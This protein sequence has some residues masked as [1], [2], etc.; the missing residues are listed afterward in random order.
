MNA[1]ARRFLWFGA[2]A[3]GTCWVVSLAG[4]TQRGPDT[5]QHDV[6][7]A[8]R[9]MEQNPSATPFRERAP[10][11]LAIT[12]ST[13]GSERAPAHAAL[14][15]RAEL[16]RSQ[17]HTAHP[18]TAEHEVLR[19]QQQLVGALNDAVD[20]RDAA[21]LRALIDRYDEL[22]LDDAQRLRE[23]YMHLADCLDAS[24]ATR[25][26]VR[27]NAQRYYDEARAST[28]R[29]HVRRVCLEPSN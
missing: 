18:L 1:R 24:E 8:A 27:A 4:S 22:A 15:K 13:T 29:R 10:S 25:A 9:T 21:S 2:A 23:G 3:L 20:L 5:A 28:L 6:A 12:V 17:P 11:A 26:E 19:Q 16:S 14:P 7:P